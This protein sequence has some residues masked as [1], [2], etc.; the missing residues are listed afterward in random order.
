MCKIKFKIDFNC[1]DLNVYLAY[2]L[3]YWTVS[4]KPTKISLYFSGYEIIL[5]FLM[6]LYT[7]YLFYLL[8]NLLSRNRNCF[9]RKLNIYCSGIQ[10]NQ[11]SWEK[12]HPSPHRGHY[13]W[14]I[15]I[16]NSAFLQV[17]F[18]LTNEKNKS[19]GC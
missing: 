5:L 8:F 6:I 15:P 9:T 19:S 12:C 1:V 18:P 11:L 2:S 3:L 13:C 16:T 17:F 4:L 14:K 10:W 7:S